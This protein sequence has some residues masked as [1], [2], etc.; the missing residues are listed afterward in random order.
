MRQ[1][2]ADLQATH[3]KRNEGIAA[4]GGT[5]GFDPLDRQLREVGQGAVLDLTV[6]AVGL[7]QQERGAGVAV[8]HL[9]DVHEAANQ[10]DAAAVKHNLPPRLTTG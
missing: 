7:A 3:A 1:R 10:T 6:H 2:A 9:G 4:Q 8:G 5:Q